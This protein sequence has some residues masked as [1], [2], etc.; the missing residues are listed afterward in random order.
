MKDW[1]EMLRQAKKMA[2][3]QSESW[4]T[5]NTKPCTGC[6]APIQKNGGCNHITCSRCRGHFCWV[7]CFPTPTTARTDT[8][9]PGSNVVR[10]FPLYS[11]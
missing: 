8:C 1:N 11:T 7:G 2:A 4:L 10:E 6:G 5:Q 3:S 9:P